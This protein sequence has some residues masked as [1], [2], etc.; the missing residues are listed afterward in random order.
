MVVEEWT[1]PSDVSK[2]LFFW[3]LNGVIM[4]ERS[5]DSVERKEK[6]GRE[7]VAEWG[8]GRWWVPFQLFVI[9]WELDNWPVFVDMGWYEDG[10]FPE[11][12]GGERLNRGVEH[13]M[14]WM[15]LMVVRL[16]AWVFGVEGV[17]E[18]RTPKALWEA[19]MHEKGQ[20]KEKTR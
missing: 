15:V 10:S 7:K 14:T 12:I 17:K 16:I 20:V 4:G 1:S 2:P 9:F 19:W 5:N 6:S 13:T 8:L 18:E 3:N 11:W